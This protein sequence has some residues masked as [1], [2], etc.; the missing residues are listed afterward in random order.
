MT[1]HEPLYF[2]AT[3]WPIEGTGEARQSQLHVALG[4]RPL[5]LW[6]QQQPALQLVASEPRH[7]SSPHPGN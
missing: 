1:A 2:T 3:N 6:Q 5:P 7:A 4:L